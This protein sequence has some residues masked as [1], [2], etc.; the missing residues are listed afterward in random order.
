[1]PI[2]ECGFLQVPPP[3]SPATALAAI[4][5]TTLVHVGFDPSLFGTATTSAPANLP[6]VPLTQN[7]LALINTGAGES[8][9]DE[10]LAQQLQ[11]PLVDTGQVS[12]IGGSTTVNV[13]LAHIVLPGLTTTQYGRFAGVHLAAGQQVHRVLIGRS[14][15][16]DTI[17]IYDGQS[18]SVKLAK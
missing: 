11:L 2:I 14:L 16:R 5:P 17:L 7:V 3:A 13:Y 9:I 6:A 18:G 1:V 12:G 4:G 15:L 10:A 8:C